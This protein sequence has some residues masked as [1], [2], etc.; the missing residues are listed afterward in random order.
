MRVEP[1]VCYRPSPDHAATFAAPPYDVFDRAA[2]RDYV[3]AHPG[4]FLEVDRPETGFPPDHDMYAPEVYAHAEDILHERAHDGTLVHDGTPCYYLYRLVR[5]GRAQVGVVA[6]CALDD[7]LDG[8]IRRHELTRPEKEEDRVRHIR[9]T[10]CQTGPILLAYRDDPT[11]DLLVSMAMASD[12]LYDFTDDEGIRQTVWRIARPAAVEALR[13][14]WDKIPCA[15]IADGHH[16]A[17]SAARVCREMREK[18]AA[19]GEATD[20]NAASDYLLAVL[21]PASQLTILPYERIV[22]DTNDLDEEALV[23]LLRGNGVEVGEREDAAPVVQAPGTLG[24]HAFGAWRQLRLPEK[25]ADDPVAALDV[26]QVQELVLEPV[27]G[28]HDPTRD[29]RISYVGGTVT[30][31][32]LAAMAGDKGVALSLSAT[33]MDEIMAV[34]DV[35]GLMPPKSTWFEPKLRSGLF[36]RVIDSY[37][38]LQHDIE[39]GI[40]K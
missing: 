24:I 14:M 33:R 34:A 37:R 1:F 8:T 40:S 28:I 22:A 17:A 10:G 38:W 2:A 11:M 31:E 6:A 13:V 23:A 35:Q 21:F 15:Y 4:S 5:E 25:P 36:V 16:R 3:A 29:P 7:Y 19:E 20:A 12:P 30:P 26:S 39:H 32:E 18:R 9:T 27:L